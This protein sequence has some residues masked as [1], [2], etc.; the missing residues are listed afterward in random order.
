MI[1]K[2]KQDLENERP[3][4]IVYRSSLQQ[5]RE[6]FEVDKV[7]A[8]ELAIAIVEMSIMHD[9]STDDAMIKAM[10]KPQEVMVERNRQEYD[11]KVEAANN[12]KIEK[13]R[14]PEIAEMV[15]QGMKQAEIAKVIGVSQQ[16]ISNRIKKIEI[17][18]PYLKNT[19]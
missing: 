18:Y 1:E 5:I 15:R 16:T 14:L 3:T 7:K 17:E 12:S 19:N 4:G 9:T 13:L 6:V 8:G 11:A 10:L 2:M